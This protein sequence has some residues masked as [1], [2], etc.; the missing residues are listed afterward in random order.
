MEV[1]LWC[2]RTNIIYRAPGA[3]GDDAAYIFYV[4]VVLHGSAQIMVGAG[5]DTVQKNIASV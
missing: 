5:T 3:I 1:W 4:F 2:L